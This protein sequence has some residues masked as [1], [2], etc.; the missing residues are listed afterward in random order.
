MKEKKALLQEQIYD[1]L[2]E[3]IPYL[4]AGLTGD[5]DGHEI[6]SFAVQQAGISGFR[7]V[8]R[9]TGFDDSGNT[10]HVVGFTTG[11][12]PQRALLLAESGYRDNVIQW[13]IDQFAK[14][15]GSNGSS[16]NERVGLVLTK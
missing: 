9:A 13:K 12:T 2:T 5:T 4:L 1:Q 14:S 8:T 7:V 3:C 16:K 15:F 11:D 6:N 10:V